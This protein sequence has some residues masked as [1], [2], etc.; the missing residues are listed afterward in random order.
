MNAFLKI[1]LWFVG[2][3]VVLIVSLVCYALYQKKV[4]KIAPATDMLSIG[5][6]TLRDSIFTYLKGNMRNN[7]YVSIGIIDGDSI[8]YIGIKRENGQLKN[9]DLRDSIFQIGSI[10]KVFTTSILAQMVEDGDVRIDET[11]DKYLGYSL[12]NDLKITFKSLANHTSGLDRMPR[13]T[14]KNTLLNFNNPYADYT[15]AWMEDYLKTEVEIGKDNVGKSEYS[16]LGMSV[17]G[18]TLAKMKNT[19]YDSLYQ[20]YIFSKYGM[21]SSFINNESNNDLITQA[22]ESTQIVAPIWSLNVFA[23]AGGI[24]SNIKDMTKFALQQFDAK[25]NTI[26]LAHKPTVTVKEDISCGLG[27]MIIHKP[28]ENELLW[29]NG[30]VGS[31]GGYTSSIVIDKKSKKAVIILSTIHFQDAGGNLDKLAFALVR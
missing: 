10:S 25:N 11:I 2:V 7:A 19:S 12:F 5:E 29:H 9:V 3:L 31:V 28:D 22:Y 24:A 26:A 18:Y 14:L 30:A 15:D 27:W 6:T 21:S 20:N 17:L 23:P 1:F 8:K 16:N 4:N 13:G